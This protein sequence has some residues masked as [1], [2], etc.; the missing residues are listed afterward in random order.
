MVRLFSKYVT[1]RSLG[2]SMTS[3]SLCETTGSSLKTSRSLGSSQQPVT[4]QNLFLRLVT[5]GFYCVTKGIMVSR[6]L[7]FSYVKDRLDAWWRRNSLNSS[8]QPLLAA[9]RSSRP[10]TYSWT[11]KRSYWRAHNDGLLVGL[12][13]FEGGAESR[14]SLRCLKTFLC[15][16]HNYKQMVYVVLLDQCRSDQ[17]TYQSLL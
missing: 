1:F 13:D 6:T 8:R 3:M 15:C 16:S 14:S 9:Q 12:S 10:Q 2:T 7:L 5:D 4:H 11:K 17:E